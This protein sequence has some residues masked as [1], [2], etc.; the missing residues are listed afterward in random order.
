[1][2]ISD[3]IKNLMSNNN[4]SALIPVIN[5]LRDNSFDIKKTISG[6]TPETLMKLGGELLK[7][8]V[9]EPTFHET[10]KIGVS[11]IANIADKDIVYILN[12]YISAEY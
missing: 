4:L 10:Q 5:L 1:M 11:P 12:R 7:N 9:I 3:I 6:I 8:S 2:E